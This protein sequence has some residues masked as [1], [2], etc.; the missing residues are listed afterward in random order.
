MAL[1]RLVTSAATIAMLGCS[2]G[3]S[4]RAVP[5]PFGGGMLPT[6][7]AGTQPAG[8]P[9]QVPTEA[10]PGPSSSGAGEAP[11]AGQSPSEGQ[12]PDGIGIAKPEGSGAAP[13]KEE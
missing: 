6:E 1:K 9:G 4:E 12:N 2:N 5:P 8:A 10:V 13:S 3:A 11:A 7:P